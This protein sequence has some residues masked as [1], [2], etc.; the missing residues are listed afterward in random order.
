V[1]EGTAQDVRYSPG[2][3]AAN[4]GWLSGGNAISMLLSAAYGVALARLM[5][6]ALFGDYVYVVSLQ[7][8]AA[9]LAVFGL[10]PIVVREMSNRPRE[11]ASLVGSAMLLFL[12]FSFVTMLV[13]LVAAWFFVR[14]Q[15]LYISLC[16]LSLSLIGEVVTNG[17]GP[18]FVASEKMQYR[19]LLGVLKSIILPLLVLP[20]LVLVRRLDA[21]MGAIVIAS[22]VGSGIAYLLVLRVIGRPIVKWDWKSWRFLLGQ[23]SPI[24]ATAILMAGFDRV[25]VLVLRSARGAAV[26]GQYRAVYQIL[27]IMK[28]FT[29]SLGTALLP[30]IF[31]SATQD[32]LRHNRIYGF[33]SRLSWAGFL[34]LALCISLTAQPL[35]QLM[36][37]K[38]FV[39]AAPAVALLAWCIPFIAVTFMISNFFTAV[40]KQH[41]LIHV[42]AVTL[43]TNIAANLLLTYRFG[44]M[45]AAASMLMSSVALCASQQWLAHSHLGLRAEWSKLLAL[46]VSCG[47]AFGISRALFPENPV[48]SVLSATVIYLASAFAMGG[49]GRR[50]MVLLR[51]VVTRR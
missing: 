19:A 28:T 38:E 14:E 23:S 20:V 26:C 17:A 49:L 9:P 25:D 48:L 27:A 32:P 42:W 2:R 30:T 24:F 41:Y 21:I 6:P 46:A 47:I 16:I 11:R 34:W 1:S 10:Y 37:G 36:Y 15:Q 7:A 35:I 51:E 39:A 40:R 50:E 4:M 22:F 29:G 31:K 44:I 13:L 43:G 8:I 33:V 3:I 12:L 45:G 5:G 18:A